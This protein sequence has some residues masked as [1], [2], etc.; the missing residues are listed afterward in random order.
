MTFTDLLGNSAICAF[1]LDAI[2]EAFD[3][4]LFLE[5]SPTGHTVFVYCL[6]EIV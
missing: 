4:S 6:M 1:R 3:N 2:N 5:Q